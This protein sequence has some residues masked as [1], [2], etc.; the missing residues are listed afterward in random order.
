VSTPTLLGK[1]AVWCAFQIALLLVG[2][3]ALTAQRM[4]AQTAPR[5]PEIPA[6]QLITPEELNHLLQSQKPLMLHVG[7]RS[8][9]QQAHI[10]GSEYIGATSSPEGLNALRTRVKS[11]PKDALIVIYCGCCP[12]E[13][14]P[15]MHP[16]FK[17]LRNLGYTNVRV[18]YIAHNF[19]ADWVDKGYPTQ[20]GE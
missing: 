4:P 2:L 1:R 14:C 5:D 11:L 9:Y 10:P 6:K 20:K 12:W 13:R 16:A 7:F 17:E 15:N 8:M 3:C 18:L 19:G